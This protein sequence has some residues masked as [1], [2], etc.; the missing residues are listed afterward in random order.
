MRSSTRTSKQSFNSSFL[1]NLNIVSI[2]ITVVK[3]PHFLEAVI[4]KEDSFVV[5]T[6]VVLRVKKEKWANFSDCFTLLILSQET[7]VKYFF[8]LPT[9]TNMRKI[10]QK[11]NL[12]AFYIPLF[13]HE[14]VSRDLG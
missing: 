5:A 11:K 14:G 12:L 1:I 4:I 13:I 10:K 2:E 8:F 7:R 9:S 6:V 3:T